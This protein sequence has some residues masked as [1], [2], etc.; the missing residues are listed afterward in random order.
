MKNNKTVG[1][2]NL[3]LYIG[4]LLLLIIF[5]AILM[6]YTSPSSNPTPSSIKTVSALGIISAIL[7]LA[8]TGL[9]I[10]RNLGNFKG[11]IPYIATTVLVGI[12]AVIALA[13]FAYAID[14]MNNP[15]SH[16]GENFNSIIK[17]LTGTTIGLSSLLTIGITVNLIQNR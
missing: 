11:N 12:T 9:W 10:Y 6:S 14:L 3:I 1:L 8:T 5:A 15:L 16:M 7:L 4:S 2:V 13:G 17:G